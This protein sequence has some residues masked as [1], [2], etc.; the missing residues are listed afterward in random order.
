MAQH[1][2][3]VALRVSA[4]GIETANG[5]AEG[6]AA[7][8][9]DT[10]NDD[11]SLRNLRYYGPG[12]AVVPLELLRKLIDAADHGADERANDAEDFKRDGENDA[13]KTAAADARAWRAAVRHGLRIERTA[14]P[15]KPKQP[16]QRTE[17]AAHA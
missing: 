14:L 2:I 10:F 1:L 13:R 7:H 4:D 12:F 15:R 3:H 17:A 16:A 8:L 11:G 6:A 5:I 9:R